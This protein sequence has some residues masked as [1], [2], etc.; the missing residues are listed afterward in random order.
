MCPRS[1]SLATAVVVSPVYTAV[2]WQ[3]GCMLQ[4]QQNPPVQF[5][6]NEP[7]THNRNER[8]LDR[9]LMA[10]EEKQTRLHAVPIFDATPY[11]FAGRRRQ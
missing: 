2:T 9:L 4:D 11:N 1:C 7:E 6:P 5:V 3:R 10:T 8:S